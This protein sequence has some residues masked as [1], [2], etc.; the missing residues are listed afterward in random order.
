MVAAVW[1][2]HSAFRPRLPQASLAG[3]RRRFAGDPAAALR[4]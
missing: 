2:P 4:V 1:R 3:Y